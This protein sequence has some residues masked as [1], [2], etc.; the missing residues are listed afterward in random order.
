MLV[1]QKC[2]S[3]MVE[4]QC[5]TG[6][7][8]ISAASTPFSADLQEY[9]KLQSDCSG[10]RLDE[11]EA[12]FTDRIGFVSIIN[13]LAAPESGAHDELGPPLLF[14][15]R[16]GERMAICTYHTRSC[17]FLYTALTL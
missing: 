16:F 11:V 8:A 6:G 13:P 2:P 14:P 17:H 15:L 1:S 10:P 12:D 4:Q 3:G 5:A 9:C 7:L